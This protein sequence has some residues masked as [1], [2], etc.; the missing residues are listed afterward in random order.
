MDELQTGVNHSLAVL[1]QSSILFQPGETTLD[2]P[3]FGH[4]FEGMQF[5]AP[6]NLH[7]DRFAQNFS[8]AF[9]EWFPGIAT[10]AQQ[11]LYLS[12]AWPATLQGLQ[13]PFTIGHFR[14]RHRNSMQQTWVSTVIPDTFLPVS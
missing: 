9:S 6:G 4:N 5:T 11:T 10:V 12:Q 13:C 14:R 8:H 1:P 7:C 3:A 2:D